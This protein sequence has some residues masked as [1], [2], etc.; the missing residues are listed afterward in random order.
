MSSGRS[1]APTI[2]PVVL[3]GG[4]GTRL[5]PLS[6]VDYPKQLLRL[7]GEDTLLRQT[8]QRLDGLG[9]TRTAS[10]GDRELA[11]GNATIVCNEQHRFL[12]RD[13][14][15]CTTHR[16]AR[17]VLEPVGRNTAPALTAA[18]LLADCRDGDPALLVMPA[19]HVIEEIGAFQSAVI[20]AADLV[21]EHVIAT[22]GIEPGYPETGYGYIELGDLVVDGARHPNARRIAAFVEKPDPDTAARYVAERRF[23]WN[24]GMFLVRASV[25]LELVRR[26]QPQMLSACQSAVERGR[27]EEPYYW[28]EPQA[29]AAS[30]SDSID[31]AVMERLAGPDAA[32]DGGDAFG[33]VVIP[34]AAG[35]SDL[36]AWP[37]VL[38]RGPR[39]ERGN[40]AVGDVYARNCRD[41]LV[42][43]EGRFVAALGL[44]D[45]MVIETADAV[46]VADR[47][48]A[49]AVK[50][51]V[52]WLEE[53]GRDE[54]R[55][56]RNRHE[57]WGTLE[58]LHLAPGWRVERL[59]VRP[60]ATWSCAGA[61][62]TAERL[63]VVSGTAR[64]SYADRTRTLAPGR[65]VS[66]D[67]GT[68]YEVA[69]PGASTLE[70]VRVL[71]SPDE[72][73]ARARAGGDGVPA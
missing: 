27:Q 5:W 53:Q 28:L 63:V 44:T 41:A 48:H 39:D 73:H 15:E 58:S 50:E 68:G 26:F 67:T 32:R 35:W 47:A 65:S 56:H 18:A 29:F 33:A 16:D 21:R 55:V 31:Y 43:A 24:S 69:N 71:V 12:V 66:L 38:A 13:Q 6:R 4:I 25:W 30:P 40:V 49:Q 8:L 70:L 64:I 22:F 14:L 23:L 9:D 2:V 34:M 59:A 7:G 51:V 62:A 20:A 72:L 45:T 17:I 60:G 10:D 37:S 11:V 36:G 52:G 46:L 61:P 54:A 19:D 1:S 3:A 57:P 42:L